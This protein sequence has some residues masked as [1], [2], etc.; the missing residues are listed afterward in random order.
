MFSKTD[1]VTFFNTPERLKR[2]SG[3]R[4]HLSFHFIEDIPQFC[5]NVSEPI[6]ST[7]QH[8]MK[9]SNMI[10]E[11]GK[12]LPASLSREKYSEIV[13]TS[14][15]RQLKTSLLTC[16]VYF[17]NEVDDERLIGDFTGKIMSLSSTKGI[18]Y[19]DAL[20]IEDN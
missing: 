10:E 20:D 19:G 7:A 6:V 14:M 15:C 13:T 1:P 17:Q 8:M 16:D 3:V 12:K 2:I 9:L 4:V 5:F 11:V 18:I